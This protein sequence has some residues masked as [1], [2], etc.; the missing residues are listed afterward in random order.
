MHIHK[1]GYPII[2]ISL[3][4]V[5]LILFFVIWLWPHKHTVHIVCIVLGLM[6]SIWTIAFFRVPHRKLQAEADSVYSSADGTVVVVEDVFEPEYFKDIRKQVSVF[7]SPFNVHVNWFPFHSE[8]VYLKYH[9]G[10]FLIA[11]HPKSSLLNER[12]SIVFRDTQGREVLVRQIAGILAR[13]ILCFTKTGVVGNAGD[14]FGIIRFGSRVDFYLPAD[15]KI[16]VKLGD[17]VKGKKTVLA[18]LN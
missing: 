1:V 13:R 17:K 12:N 8:V 6:W 10:K 3:L 7:M 18:I 2:F 4:L 9:P 5:V 14:E 16:T 11:N 15:T